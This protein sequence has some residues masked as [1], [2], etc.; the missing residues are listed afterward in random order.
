M[1]K[2]AKAEAEVPVTCGVEVI[3]G[4]ETAARL[5]VPVGSVVSTREV[6]SSVSLV[7][8]RDLVRKL[9]KD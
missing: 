8:V 7:R 6:E 2:V 4:P 1:R 3:A 5:G 9:R